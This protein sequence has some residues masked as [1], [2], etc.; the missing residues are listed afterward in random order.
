MSQFN[1][2]T[3]GL[4][5]NQVELSGRQ[6]VGKSAIFRASSANLLE[7]SC[8]SLVRVHMVLRNLGC[9]GGLYTYKVRPEK[10]R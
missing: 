7:A 3:V 6:S 2:A 8:R 1:P 4:Q 9:I 10:F 5:F